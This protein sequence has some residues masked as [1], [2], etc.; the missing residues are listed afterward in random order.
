MENNEG[1]ILLT[2]IALVQGTIVETISILK[3]AITFV[4]KV[5]LYNELLLQDL[6]VLDVNLPK[7]NGQEVFKNIN[8]NDNFKQISVVMYTTSYII[9]EILKECKN[10]ANCYITKANGIHDFLKTVTLNKNF[11]I[12]IVH[13]PIIKYPIK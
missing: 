10:H 11:R 9:R 13:L 2:G 7:M 4:E 3:E 6:I 5:A 1:D 8:E 12:S